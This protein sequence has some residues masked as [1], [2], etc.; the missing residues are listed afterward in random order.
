MCLAKSVPSARNRPDPGAYNQEARID[1]TTPP[2]YAA[3]DRSPFLEL[4]L[5]TN[6]PTNVDKADV[7]LTNGAEPYAITCSNGLLGV[8]TGGIA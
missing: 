7:N 8:G 2:D 3:T 4:T 6:Q 1:A 5:P